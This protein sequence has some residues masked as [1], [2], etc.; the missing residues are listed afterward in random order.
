MRAGVA[1]GLLA[2]A[3]WGLTFI[4]PLGVA[5]FTG[6]DLTV[7][8]FAAY[9]AASLALLAPGGF[10]ALRRLDRRTV[11][12][13]L[14]LGF[15]GYAGYYAAIALAVPLAGAPLVALII[16]ALPLV[17]ALAGHAQG[18]PPLRRLAWP[19][20]LVAAGLLVIN[21]AAF[22]GAGDASGRAALALGVAL[23]VLGLALWSVYG[24]RNAAALAARPGTSTADW[25]ALTGLG[26]FVSLL[27]MIPFAWVMGLTGLP[28]ALTDSAA[29]MRLVFWGLV[30]GIGASLIATWLWAIASRR[31]PVSLAAQLIVSE[32]VFGVLYGLA[33]EWRAPSL[34]ELMGSV[35][36]LAGVIAAIGIFER[37]RRM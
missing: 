36:L 8:R 1:A 3:L 2:G 29:A 15:T 34:A 28:A 27:P 11:R 10:R 7:V 19:L 12:E 14:L 26:A 31:L 17:L 16:G 5:P 35:L 24:L 30:T 21:G 37:T 9:A 33:W 4:A 32:T 20:A 23:A 6:F 25:A 18:N 13:G 22:R